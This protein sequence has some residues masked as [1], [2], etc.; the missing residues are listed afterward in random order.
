VMG[1]DVDADECDVYVFVAFGSSLQ[2]AAASRT[3]P[4]SAMAQAKSN[5]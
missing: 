3:Q 4:L 2:S 5:N 1:S